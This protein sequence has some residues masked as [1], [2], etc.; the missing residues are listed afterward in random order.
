MVSPPQLPLPRPFLTSVGHSV[1]GA[2]PCLHRRQGR[3]SVLPDKSHPGE[4]LNNSIPSQEVKGPRLV[5]QSEQTDAGAD[6]RAEIWKRDTAGMTAFKP[7]P[8]PPAAYSLSVLG[9]SAAPPHT[10]EASCPSSP[11]CE[12]CFGR[13]SI[14]ESHHLPTAPETWI[15]SSSTAL[16]RGCELG[17]ERGS[18]HKNDS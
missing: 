6:S 12:V 17:T 9:S 1:S 15:P 2:S 4:T 7:G 8:C 5:L 18:V 16:S 10:S 14:W 3:T 11:A 13:M